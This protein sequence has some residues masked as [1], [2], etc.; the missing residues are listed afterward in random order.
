M[1]KDPIYNSDPI[2]ITGFEVIDLFCGGGL[3]SDLEL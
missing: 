3:A 2:V 1:Y